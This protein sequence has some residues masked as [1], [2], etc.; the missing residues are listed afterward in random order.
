[1]YFGTTA[2]S[3]VILGFIDQ[4]IGLIDLSVALI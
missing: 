4:F 2:A 3:A 1:M